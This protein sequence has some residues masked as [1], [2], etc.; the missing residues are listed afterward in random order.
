MVIFVNKSY[1]INK[2]KNFSIRKRPAVNQSENMIYRKVLSVKT[3][4]RGERSLIKKLFRKEA[5]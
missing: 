5:G 3:Y 4:I 1:L 2:N